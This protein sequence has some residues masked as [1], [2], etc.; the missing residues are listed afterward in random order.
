MFAKI[1][2]NGDKAAPLYQYLTSQETNPQHAGKISW[3]FEKFLIGRDGKIVSRFKTGVQPEQL[4][5]A[6]EA[7][8]AKK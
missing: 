2:V 5:D 7:E 3:N 8:I 1:D 4:T 6:I